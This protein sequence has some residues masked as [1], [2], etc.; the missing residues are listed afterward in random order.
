MYYSAPTKYQQYSSVDL[1][2]VATIHMRG[3]IICC[4]ILYYYNVDVE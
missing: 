4:N 3:V 2:Y 1:K